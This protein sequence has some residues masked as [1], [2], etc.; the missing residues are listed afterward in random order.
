M[1]S[2]NIVVSGGGRMGHLYVGL[3]SQ[4]PNVRVSWHTRRAEAIKANMPAE[5]MSLDVEG[6]GT[7]CAVPRKVSSDPA[8]LL[9]DADVILLTQTA[10]GRPDVLRAMAPW[11]PTDRKVFLGGSPGC[12]GFDWLVEAIIGRRPN[13]VTWAFRSVPW[14]CPSIDVGRA[15]SAIGR[16]TT[17]Y[18]GF[19]DGVTK[20]DRAQTLE[21]LNAM[22]DM[23]IEELGHFLDITLSPKSIMHPSV[24]YGLM[25]PY[26]QWSGNPFPERIRWWTDLSRLGAY[27]LARCDSEQQMIVHAAEA[28]LGIKLPGAGPLKEKLAETY[29][30]HIGQSDTLLNVL[31]TNSA[32]RSFIPF[33]QVDGGYVFDTRMPG[34]QEDIFFGLA[35][36]IA[37]ADRLNVNVPHLR[38][39][40]D[41]CQQLVGES[42]ETAVEYI[43]RAWPR[44]AIGDA[45]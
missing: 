29:A 19:A 15:A 14:N 35:L 3:L 26:S 1:S 33:V 2:L 43:P 10:N 22:F 17:V 16:K 42:T 21:M 24:L 37:L 6:V 11:L 34:L 7:V 25:G 32:Y 45:A 13:V 36:L 41:F 4:L 38:E 20:G 5:G 8:E 31:R 9:S 18:V 28:A 12:G 39:V 40:M 30:P 44:A 27:I 23:P